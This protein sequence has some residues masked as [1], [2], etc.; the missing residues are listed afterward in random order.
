MADSRQRLQMQDWRSFAAFLSADV[1]Q[2]VLRTDLQMFHVLQVVA[3]HLVKLGLRAPSEPTQAMVAAL[4]VRRIGGRADDS[5][6]LRNTY[7]H[8]KAQ[9]GTIM[10]KAKGDGQPIPGGVYMVDLPADPS[11][12]CEETR[13]V[14]FPDGVT[15]ADTFSLVELVAIARNVP[16]RNTNNNVKLAA[17]QPSGGEIMWN[18]FAQMMSAGARSMSSQQRQEPNIT[19]LQQPPRQD[20]PLQGLL[21]RAHAPSNVPAAAPQQLALPAPPTAAA[22]ETEVG[23]SKDE[24]VMEPPPAAQSVPLPAPAAAEDGVKQMGLAESIGRLQAQ[25]QELRSGTGAALASEDE[26][27]GPRKRPAKKAPPKP[28]A[29]GSGAMKRPAAKQSTQQKPKV[30]KAK[31]ALS[32]NEKHAQEKFKRFKKIM[33]M[34]VLLQYKH[35]CPRCRSAPWC[36]PCCWRQRG[37]EIPSAK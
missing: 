29:R 25:R 27:E 21:D 16:L 18:A 37:F 30:E 28:V 13:A 22:T 35:G 6:L 12:V 9:L 11:Q 31:K 26:V 24:V 14:A 34:A 7:L 4:M 17:A 8:V 1:W 33:P 20:A 15:P 32:W 23:V 3:G 36:T 10:L 5:T 2:T 19:F